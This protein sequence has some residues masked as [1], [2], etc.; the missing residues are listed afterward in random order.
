MKCPSSKPFQ[1]KREY[2]SLMDRKYYAYTL[3]N[4]ITGG[5]S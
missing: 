4:K 5:A 2:V 3:V 1:K